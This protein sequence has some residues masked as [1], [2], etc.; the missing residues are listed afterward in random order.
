MPPSSR[1]K[2]PPLPSGGT[3]GCTPVGTDGTK[4]AVPVDPTHTLPVVSS[5][6]SSSPSPG[7]VPGGAGNGRSRPQQPAAQLAYQ[8]AGGTK[9]GST[10]SSQDDELNLDAN[11]FLNKKFNL[12]KSDGTTPNATPPPSTTA[13]PQ[14]SPGTKMAA[15]GPKP[16]VVAAIPDAPSAQPKQP[17]YAHCPLGTAPPTSTY[18]GPAPSL[19][20][21]DH[22]PPPP[23]AP[24]DVAH[25]QSGYDELSEADMMW[26]KYANPKQ[27]QQPAATLVSQQGVCTHTHTQTHTHTHTQTHTHTHT[28]TL[29][30]SEV[31]PCGS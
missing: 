3:A 27:Q 8:R 11:E 5:T 25:G 10:P 2:A 22:H 29:V 1:A 21:S 15:A 16:A 17:G 9:G 14:S 6:H 18:T 23:H 24:T 7:S 12:L 19:Y 4:P 30:H 26:N 20:P 28:Y 31:A 13:I